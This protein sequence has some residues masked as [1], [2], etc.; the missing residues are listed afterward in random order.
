MVM[1]PSKL[2]RFVTTGARYVLAAV[3]L[4]SAI[5]KLI[6]PSIFV[7]FVSSIDWLSPINPILLLLTLTT[8]EV[9]V[10]VLL[11]LPATHKIAGLVSFGVLLLFSGALILTSV[12]QEPK[13][14]GCFGDLIPESST[15]LSL[16][17]NVVL[18]VL[19]VLVIGS[20]MAKH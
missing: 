9:V 5:G 4:F 17:R 10:A 15:N 7:A 13:P 12:G 11:L 14:C 8:I 3:F 19:S 20:S 6:T 1:N 18:L 2:S 16:L